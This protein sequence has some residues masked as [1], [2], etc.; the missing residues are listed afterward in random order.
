[1]ILWASIYAT[2]WWISPSS[3]LDM[4]K[5]YESTKN[6]YPKLI[7]VWSLEDDALV[8]CVY[9]IWPAWDIGST[10]QQQAHTAIQYLQSTYNTS[11]AGI[12]PVETGIE[13]MMIPLCGT[14]DIPLMDADVVWWRAV[15]ELIY[16]NFLLVWQSVFPLIAVDNRMC[17]HVYD[18][19]DI[20]Q[21]DE[22]LRRLVQKTWWSLIC[23][24]HICQ[25]ATL[26]SLWSLGVLSRS[27]YT[28]SLI[29]QWK[30]LDQIDQIG[31][32]IARGR[33]TQVS[34]QTKWWFRIWSV[35][36]K[37]QKWDSERTVMVKNEYMQVC[38]YWCLIS[39]PEL[40]VI[41]DAQSGIWIWSNEIA[42]WD[43]VILWSIPCEA[44]WR[45]Y[46]YTQNHT[47]QKQ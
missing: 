42:I 5:K 44:R 12:L 33:V 16:D 22:T 15:P 32:I 37:D 30:L 23:V 1:M 26:R 20:G 27:V 21:L 13:M 36:I 4:L 35:T 38:K 19:Q 39:F 46:V 31:N 6:P 17:I 24:D 25:A 28:W 10:V 45:N 40:I 9:G 2:W 34:L 7:T 41:I 3:Q 43:E 29:Q 14:L 8:A 47:Q 11:L 18:E